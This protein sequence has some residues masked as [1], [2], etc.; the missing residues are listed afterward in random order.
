MRNT[1][2]VLSEPG[3]VVVNAFEPT[4]QV[5]AQATWRLADGSERPVCLPAWIA[6]AIDDARAGAAV[7]V[8]LNRS[9]DPQPPSLGQDDII[10]N[11]LIAGTI[12]PAGAAMLLFYCYR[13]CRLALDRHRLAR[14]GQ[15]WTATGP[16]WTRQ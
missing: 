13:L 5:Q 16:R 4:A 2:A 11:T 14:W 8:W 12:I 1:V 15:A 3:P 6:P 9:G 7:L 10:L